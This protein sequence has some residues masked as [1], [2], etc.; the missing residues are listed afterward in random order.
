MKDRRIDHINNVI[1]PR[2]VEQFI[3]S[4]YLNI[5]WD[6]SDKEFDGYIDHIRKQAFENW[7]AEEDLE[8]VIAD[9]KDIAS[10]M[11]GLTIDFS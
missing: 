11:E 1:Q 6:L 5:N 2:D 9:W 3:R 4:C 10:N 7:Y 8:K